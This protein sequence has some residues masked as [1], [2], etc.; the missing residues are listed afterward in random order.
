MD[1]RPAEAPDNNDKN[2]SGFDMISYNKKTSI[3]DSHCT[4]TC[5]LYLALLAYT[6]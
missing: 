4:I 6:T 1:K 2:I 3:T 5:Q